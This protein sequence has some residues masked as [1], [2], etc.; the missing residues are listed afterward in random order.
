[1]GNYKNIEHDFIDRTLK[2]IS[3]YESILHKYPFEE[4]YNYTLLINSL[5]GIIVFPKERLFNHIPNLRLTPELKKEMGLVESK[6]N[7]NYKSL[8]DLI[9]GMRNSIAH[10]TVEI[11]SQTDDFLVDNIVFNKYDDKDN[12]VIADFK[13]TELLPFIRYY[14]DWTKSNLLENPKK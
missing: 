3:Q 13:S 5:L 14:A 9:Y 4:Q 8:R 11:V 1:M 6:I 12:T 7:P 10:F 2:L